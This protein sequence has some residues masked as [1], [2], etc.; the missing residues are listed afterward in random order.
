MDSTIQDSNGPELKS[1]PS[2]YDYYNIDDILATQE[3]VPSKLEVQIHNLGFLDPN[4]EGGDLQA[5]S[6]FELPFWLAKDLCSRRRRIVSVEMPKTYREG[7]RQILKADANVVDLHKL[8]PYYYNFGTKL[9]HFSF[10]ENSQIAKS[11]QEV[12]LGS[13]MRDR[14]PHRFIT[15]ISH[16]VSFLDLI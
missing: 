12:S 6:K 7:Y 13:G 8:G 4:S 2:S 3:R 14:L 9:L 11:L 16:Q 5:G 15:S 1:R 10:E